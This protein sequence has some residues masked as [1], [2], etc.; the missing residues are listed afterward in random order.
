MD[1]HLVFATQ[2]GVGLEKMKEVM[3]QFAQE[4]AYVFA[5]DSQGRQNALFR[6]DEPAC[7]ADEM[8]Q[9]FKGRTVSYGEVQQYALNESPF[10]NPKKML[11]SLE[12]AER[13]RV[14]CDKPSRRIGQYPH[15]R[16]HSMRIAFLE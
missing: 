3:K 14:T 16:H 10:T 9:E 6:F 8:A 2:H 12:K 13:I 7:H 15:H 1:Y 11:N 5:D 4:G